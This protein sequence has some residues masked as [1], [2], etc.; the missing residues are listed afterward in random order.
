QLLAGLDASAVA[1]LDLGPQHHPL[2]LALAPAVVDHRDLAVAVEDDDV[3]LAVQDPAHVVVLEGPVV[4]RVVGR[5]LGY[6]AG[7]APDVEGAHGE[8]RARLPDGLGGDDAH[9]LAELGQAPGAE[10]PPVAHH[11]DAA[12]GLAGEGGANAHPLQAGV[13]DALGQLL[14]DLGVGLHDDLAGEGIADVL[15]GHPAQHAVA[16]GLDQLA[17]LEQRGGVDVAHG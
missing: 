2:P 9:R 17:A 13:L 8:L 14:V 5:G 6:A 15:G 10:I 12:L 16:Q 11:A 4:L 1:L 3:T 7:G